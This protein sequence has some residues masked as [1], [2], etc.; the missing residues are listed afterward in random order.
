M[1][2]HDAR[3]ISDALAT[4]ARFYPRFDLDDQRT[5]DY[6]RQLS[7]YPIELVLAAIDAAPRVYTFFPSLHELIALIS[8][9]VAGDEGAADL[10]WS[11]V[12]REA[13]RVGYNRPPLYIGG[14][15]QPRPVASFSSPII[16]AAVDSVGWRVICTGDN[17]SG[18]VSEQFKRTYRRLAKTAQRRIQLGPA[19]STLS[20]INA[21]A[22]L[23]RA[24]Q[25]RSDEGGLRRITSHVE[26]E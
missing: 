3:K 8:D 20:Q 24:L 12:Q 13:S 17:D 19:A 14:V 26:D 6:V 4:C 5:A 18:N 23:D 10:A 22:S 11:E 25:A 2:P 16:S 1:N 15:E 9:S 21:S 7:A